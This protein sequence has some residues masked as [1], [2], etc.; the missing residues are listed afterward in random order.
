MT[1]FVS[2]DMHLEMTRFAPMTAPGTTED[3]TTNL[4]QLATL[5]V[6]SNVSG[7]DIEVDGSFVGN[8]P[9][10]ISVAPGQHTIAVKKKGFG[11]WNRT[12][13]VSGSNVRLSA[14]LE[15]QP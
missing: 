1:A 6:D 4:V 15:T 10:T 7:A 13:N 14:E 12:M 3:T 11:D 9:S 2:G 8:T 5:A